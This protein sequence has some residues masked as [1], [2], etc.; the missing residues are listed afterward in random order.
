MGHI[1]RVSVSPNHQGRSLI[2]GRPVQ[3]EQKVC[4]E[5]L[6][7]LRIRCKR[8]CKTVL[9]RLAAGATIEEIFL[10]WG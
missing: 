8:R 3:F 1:E 7:L 9:K 10:G 4:K 5:A 6:D 2:Q